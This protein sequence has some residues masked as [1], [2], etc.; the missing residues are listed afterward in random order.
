MTISRNISV[1]AQGASSSGIL[2]GSYGGLGANISPTTAGN[3][4]FTT[5]GTTW[6]STAKIVSANSSSVAASGSAIDFTNIPSWVKRI[7]VMVDGVSNA[8]AADILI[9]LGTSGG[10]VSTGYVAS[11]TATST[12]STGHTA[13]TAGFPMRLAAGTSI[14]YGIMTI[15]L[16]GT[17]QFAAAHTARQ[18]AT[19]SMYG[20][21][22]VTLGGTLTQ[23]RFTNTASDSFDLGSVNIMYE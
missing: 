21:G 12:A 7:T 14:C 1:M 8:G 23:L 18:A 4:L 2:S 9:Q 20:G 17:N 5:N 10:I 16:M 19:S 6:S 15:C 13:S 22:S 3:T 11:S